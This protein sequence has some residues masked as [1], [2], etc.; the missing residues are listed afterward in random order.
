[1]EGR[2]AAGKHLETGVTVAKL[3]V[4]TVLGHKTEIIRQG[5]GTSVYRNSLNVTALLSTFFLC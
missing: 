4:S 3:T 5:F 1:M 2:W